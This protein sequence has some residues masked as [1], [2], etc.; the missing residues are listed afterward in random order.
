MSV[1]YTLTASDCLV[2]HPHFTQNSQD[3][4]PLQTSVLACLCTEFMAV[5]EEIIHS[6]SEVLVRE[7]CLLVAHVEKVGDL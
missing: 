6:I 3:V 2:S 4:V 5:S 7:R 1:S